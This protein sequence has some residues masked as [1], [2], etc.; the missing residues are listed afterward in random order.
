M[1][2]HFYFVGQIEFGLEICLVHQRL[3]L[4]ISIWKSI[5]EKVNAVGTTQRSVTEVKDKWRNMCGVEEMRFTEHRR[6]TQKTGGGGAPPAP[7]SQTVA[8][9]VDLYKGCRSFVGV[10]G[11]IETQISN[12]T[13]VLFYNSN[14]MVKKN[15]IYCNP[16]ILPSE[17]CPSVQLTNIPI[18]CIPFNDIII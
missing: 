4:N 9:I 13:G 11:G 18:K 6:E 10:S 16:P 12:Q 8:D 5:T 1:L 2:K 3:I 7:L 14:I 17:S 15:D